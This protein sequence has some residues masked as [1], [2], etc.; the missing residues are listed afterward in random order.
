M[1]VSIELED[2]PKYRLLGPTWSLRFS[3]F[4]I[5]FNG[6]EYVINIIHFDAQIILNL[7]MGSLFMLEFAS[8]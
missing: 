1:S 7:I 5:L 8:I 4:P 6:L 2:K 3:R